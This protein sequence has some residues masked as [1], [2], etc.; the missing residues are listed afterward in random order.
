[1]KKFRHEGHS[2]SVYSSTV[3]GAEGEPDNLKF[4]GA[5]ASALGAAFFVAGAG[6]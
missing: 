6:V 4:F 1:L 2:K 3:M 5:A